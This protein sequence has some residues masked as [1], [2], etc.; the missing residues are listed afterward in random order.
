MPLMN[1]NIQKALQVAGLEK[2]KG[3]DSSL[4]EKLNEENLGLSPL[5]GH[6]SD[7]ILG[8]GNE[9][10]KMRAIEAALKMHGVLKDQAAPPPSISIIINDPQSTQ[11]A[12][13]PILI[14]RELNA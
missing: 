11:F 12:V 9:S 13:N 8:A 10:T 3:E 2:K 5:L 7:L 6:L 14:P 4:T 1:P